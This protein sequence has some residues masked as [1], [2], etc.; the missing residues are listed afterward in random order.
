MAIARALATQPDVL[1]CD[2]PTSALDPF[3]TATVLQY[4]ADVNREFGITVVIVTHEMEVIKALADHVA[5]M[6]DGAVVEQFPAAELGREDFAPR[7]SIGRYLT[8]DGISVNR[9]GRT[10]PAA[11]AEGDQDTFEEIADERDQKIF[12][13]VEGVFADEPP[14]HHRPHP[15]DQPRD[16]GDVRHDRGLH[17]A[18]SAPGHPIGHLAVEPRPRRAEAH[19]QEPHGGLC[20]RQHGPLLPVPHPADRP[21]PVHPVHRGHVGGNGRGDRSLTINAIPYFARL[22]E[23]NITQLGSGAVEASRAMGATSGQIIRSVLLVDAKPALIG[24]ITI[25]TVSFISYS[26][27][28]G[29]VG[30]GGIGDLAIRYGYYRYETETMI[31]AC[32]LM[33]LLVSIV[34]YGGTRIARMTDKRVSA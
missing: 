18:G 10:V 25:T 1:L 28:S 21:D 22:V 19:A 32:I 3:T 15:G 6:E 12:A 11:A 29:L 2:E 4:L 16:A 23:Q 8:S 31:V 20:D 27:M 7:T 5:V 14:A 9:D 34:Q 24:S 33:V 30:G 17:P 13:A 26:A